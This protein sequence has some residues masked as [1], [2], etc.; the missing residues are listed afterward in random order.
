MLTIIQVRAGMPAVNEQNNITE[1]NQIAQGFQM[2]LGTL[3]SINNTSHQP[4]VADFIAFAERDADRLNAFF[5]VAKNTAALADL[6]KSTT[7]LGQSIQYDMRVNA[8]ADPISSDDLAK[9]NEALT[10]LQLSITPK[11]P[12][13]QNTGAEKVNREAQRI[14]QQLTSFS[15]RLE[16]HAAPEI[17]RT[18]ERISK[19]FARS[20]EKI[21]K[22]LQ[23]LSERVF[24]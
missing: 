16:T 5:L 10:V 2:L 20:G 3:T 6:I 1:N 24:F 11:E 19:E 9:L 12:C 4:K 8:G 18:G 22:E 13:Q 7:I 23:R 17:N 14:L 15:K 21:S